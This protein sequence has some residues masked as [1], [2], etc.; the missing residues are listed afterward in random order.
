MAGALS[1]KSC[2]ALLFLAISIAIAATAPSAR[3]ATPQGT[4]VAQLVSAI[5]AHALS[6]ENTAG[7]RGGF[8][9]F[10]SEYKVQ[11][12]GVRYSD[13]VIAR[14]VYEAT[15]DAGF[16]G[17]HWSIT[18]K[19]PNSDEIWKQWRASA[20]PSFVKQTATAECDELSA[21]YAFLAERSGVKGIG[22]FWPYPNHTVAVWV[23]HPAPNSFVRVVVP[24]SQ[25]FLT[26]ADDFGTKSFNP[27]TQK[28]IYEYTRR[29]APDSMELPK[30]LFDFFVTQLGKYG[31]ATDAT[32]QKIRYMRD[33]V[34]RG[35]W[36]PEQAARAALEIRASAPASL[37]SDSA[38]FLYFAQDMRSAPR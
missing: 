25:I 28:T 15:R 6:L 17:L 13:Y 4:N 27:W 20:P 32:L 34:F 35:E 22:L 36:T 18:N 33:A 9:S 31:G 37:P 5:E 12:G 2:Q 19:P 8:D 10:T 16:W 21:L 29:D 26:E 30:P 23:L 38:A 14:L 7:M 3:T 1:V 11:P 24:T